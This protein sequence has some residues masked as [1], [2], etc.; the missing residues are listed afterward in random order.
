MMMQ[1]RVQEAG[2]IKEEQ[3]KRKWIEEL[4]L[5]LR[6]RAGL[7]KN[8]TEYNKK[9]EEKIQAHIESIIENIP[10]TVK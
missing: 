4:K 9:Q 6:I 1:F 10:D 7:E 8:G 5:E 3:K 2:Y